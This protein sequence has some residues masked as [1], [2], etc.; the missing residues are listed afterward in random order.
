M[1]SRPRT[2]SIHILDDD[3]LLHV[4]YLYRPFLLGEDEGHLARLEGGT[5]RWVRGRW[6]YKLAHVCERWRYLLFGSAPYLG[7]SLVCTYGTPVADMLAHSP[8]LPLFIDYCKDLNIT[9]EDEE[10][11]ISAL[12]QR[13]RV[14]RVRLIAKL[15]KLIV[16]M[17]E[18]YPIL[19]YLIVVPSPGDTN[20]TSIFSETFQAP[21]LRHLALEGMALP[22]GSR[23]L[24]SAVGLVTLC[25]VMHHP[26]TYFHPNTLLQWISFLPQLE[27]LVIR[28]SRPVHKRDVERQLMHTPITTPVTLPNLH[29]FRFDGVSTYS[30][31]L[32]RQITTPRLEH[33]EILF[34]SQLTF[35]VPCLQQLLNTTENLK[36]DTARFGFFDEGVS[37]A[38]DFRE[39]ETVGLAI[40]VHCWHLDWQVS[41]MAQ[42]S[43]SLGQVFSVVDHLALDHGV[44]SQSSEE[45]NVI[46]RTEWRK[47]LRPFR[48]VKTLLIEEGLVEGLSRCLQLEDG[49]L[50]LELLPELQELSF[51]LDDNNSDAFTSF[52]YAR[53][54][55][56]R[57][58][59]L[60]HP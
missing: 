40:G 19:E 9:A 29:Y 59:T 1:G 55:A 60:V 2:A 6:W 52:I 50:P 28:F 17:D 54:N 32:V 48:N 23:L 51:P 46:E 14:S 43:S 11:I 33:I 27:T 49:E 18:E 58:V 26:S 38:L 3:S 5:E 53:Q 44:H 10:Q 12:K 25:L 7:I 30:E 4:F 13:D 15:Q 35:F 47:L 21:H 45:H 8:H 24:T 20:T 57:P 42:I 36:F 39:V 37:V 56:G 31:A 41:S 34:F 22:K 16:T